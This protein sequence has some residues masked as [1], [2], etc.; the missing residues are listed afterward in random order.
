MG[1]LDGVVETRPGWLGRVEV[2]EVT[3][4]PEVIS[5]HELVEEAEVRS[6]AAP[7]FTRTEAQQKV[8]KALVGDRA[9]RSD[10]EVRVEG[11]KGNS[12]GQIM[13]FTIHFIFT[14]CLQRLFGLANQIIAPHKTCH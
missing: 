13:C 9:K 4:D 2:V 1:I 5:Y 12:T 7:V 10:A 6:C 8:A 3:F 11:F 14:K